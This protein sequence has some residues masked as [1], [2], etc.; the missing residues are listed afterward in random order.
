MHGI[1]TKEDVRFKKYFK[2]FQEE[3]SKRGF[4]YFLDHT[5]AKKV[6]FQDMAAYYNTIY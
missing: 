4:V 6:C 2:M 3:I 1:R 5:E